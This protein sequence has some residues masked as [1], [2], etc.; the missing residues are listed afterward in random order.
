VALTDA[1]CRERLDDEYAAL[2]RKL[3]GILA[4]KRPSPLPRGKAESWASGIVR[5]VGWVNFLGDPSQP[6]HMKMTDIDEG[7]GVSEATGT[8]KSSAIRDMLKINRLDPEWTLPSRLEENPL[9]WMIQVNGLIVDARN[10]PRAF[11]EQAFRMGLIPHI[12][13]GPPVDPSEGRAQSRARRRRGSDAARF[14]PGAKV[15]VKSG[16]LDPDFPDIPLGGWAGT[17]KEVDEDEGR[18]V[19]LVAWGR[20][21]LRAIH[22]V[23]KKRCERDGLELETMW[24]E[25]EDLEPDD[26]PPAPIEQPTSIVTP[27]LSEKD[28][29]DRV[30]LVFGLTHDDPLP[31][32]GRVT[33]L[34]YHRYLSA[35]LKFPFKARS[36]TDGISLTVLRLLDPEEYDPDEED[37][38]LCEARGPAGPFPIP[39]H[40]L[41]AAQANR[42]PIRDYTDWFFG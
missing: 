16:V 39:L 10:M 8:A 42:K 28:Q 19:Y 9:A 11:Q 12:P 38:L 13:G 6:H 5:A 17:V 26:G 21:T 3:A 25:E 32:V 23:Y 18:P 33:L 34:A 40:E 30:R 14:R 31:D 36:E 27:P 35:N 2:C 41:D 7:F 29:D 1:F 22:P 37:G 20:A 24:L 15:R 4:R